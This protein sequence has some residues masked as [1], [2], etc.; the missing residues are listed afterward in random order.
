MRGPRERICSQN[1]AKETTG[2]AALKREKHVNDLG[3]RGHPLI[4]LPGH[5]AQVGVQALL[6]G[7][8]EDDLSQA[9]GEQP[10]CIT[11]ARGPVGGR[12]GAHGRSALAW[13][14]H[15]NQPQGTEEA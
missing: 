13:G 3:G 7:L 12:C 6:Q 4:E 1:N 15:A 11:E 8:V 5:I 10:G 2:E 14:K 9:T